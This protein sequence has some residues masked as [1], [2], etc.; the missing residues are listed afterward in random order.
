MKLATIDGTTIDLAY[1]RSGLKAETTLES[2]V[3]ISLLTDRRANIDDELPEAPTQ[4][5]IPPDRRGWCGDALSEVKGDRIGSRLWLLRR[6]KVN[7]QTRRDAIAYAEEALQWMI[8][9]RLATSVAIDAEWRTIEGVPGRLDLSI[10]LALVT[11]AFENYQ[12]TIGI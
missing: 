11:G 10:R 4:T 5:V 2:A 9:D 12:V 6:R 3:M 8:T 7:E 1:D